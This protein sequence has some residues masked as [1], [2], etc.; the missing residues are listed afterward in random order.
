[1]PLKTIKLLVTFII[2]LLVSVT[3][4]QSILNIRKNTGSNTQYALTSVRK[5]FFSAGNLTVS[6]NDATT[7]VYALNTIQ[8]LSFNNGI[9]GLN[10]L[11]ENS[12]NKLTV[13]P[14][15]TQEQLTVSFESETTEKVQMQILDVQGKLQLQQSLNCQLGTNQ[16]IISVSELP[17]GLYICQF[18]NSKAIETTKFIKF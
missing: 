14:N 9:S 10:L 3:Q 16:Q 8:N 11:S 7:A 15:P 18:I 4:A 12:T 13:Y 17:K 6:K 5:I 1:M 2:A